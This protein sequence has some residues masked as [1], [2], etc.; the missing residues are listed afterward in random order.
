MLG[1][2]LATCCFS[3]MKWTNTH[4][5]FCSFCKGG[6]EKLLSAEKSQPHGVEAYNWV[7]LCNVIFYSMIANIFFWEW[8]PNQCNHEASLT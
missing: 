3:V 6:P 1:L 2:G 7:V 4:V 5:K 8:E